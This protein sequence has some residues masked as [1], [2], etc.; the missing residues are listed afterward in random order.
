MNQVFRKLFQTEAWDAVPGI[1]P[2]QPARGEPLTLGLGWSSPEPDSSKAPI[3]TSQD[4]MVLLISQFS[5]Y[6]HGSV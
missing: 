4:T 6:S 5:S 3:S 1:L 2:Y